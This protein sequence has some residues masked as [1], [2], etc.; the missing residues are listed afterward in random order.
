MSIMSEER[1]PS[2]I[3]DRLF[4]PTKIRPLFSGTISE[5]VPR[6]N[7]PRHFGKVALAVMEVCERE[8]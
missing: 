6:Y 4:E 2:D 8:V 3:H 7:W 5:E 1:S